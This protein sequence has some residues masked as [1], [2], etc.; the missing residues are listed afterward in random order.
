MT[1][2]TA[3]TDWV[4]RALA[5]YH[6]DLRDGEAWSEITKEW[7]CRMSAALKRKTRNHWLTWSKTFQSE[8]RDHRDIPWGLR[9]GMLKDFFFHCDSHS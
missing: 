8:P 3:G 1:T 5:S 2:L 9:L 7:T 6:F 4:E